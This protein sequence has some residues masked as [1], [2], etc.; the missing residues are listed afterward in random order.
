MEWYVKV[1]RNYAE[2]EGRARRM[3]YWMFILVNLVI[4]FMLGVLEFLFG[5]SGT[6]ASLYSLAILIPGIAVS[7]RRLHDTDRSGWWILIG[8]IPLLGILVLLVFYCTGGDPGDN[9]FGPDPIG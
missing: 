2:F 6:L 8:F 9:D 7:V 3:E 4:L 5:L 1:L